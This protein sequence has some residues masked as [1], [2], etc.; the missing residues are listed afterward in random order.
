MNPLP[1]IQTVGAHR[2]GADRLLDP[3]FL[4]S[5]TGLAKSTRVVTAIPSHVV[6]LA[7]VHRPIFRLGDRRILVGVR[8]ICV[9]RHL[10]ERPD[11]RG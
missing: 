9:D 7:K 10:N 3:E 4:Y 6:A 8:A 5:E 11:S 2:V 1:G